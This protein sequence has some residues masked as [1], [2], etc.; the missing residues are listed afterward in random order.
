MREQ[1]ARGIAN[2]RPVH[3]LQQHI[4]ELLKGP[5]GGV[6]LELEADNLEHEPL[7]LEQGVILLDQEAQEG[8]KLL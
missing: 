6:Q 3:D 2:A 7:T 8:F 5:D 1:K 4:C